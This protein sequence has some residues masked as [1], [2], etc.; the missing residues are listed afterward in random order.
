MVFVFLVSCIDPYNPPQV[1]QA[2]SYLVVDGYVDLDAGSAS[3]ILSRTKNLSESDEIQP[4]INA[5]VSVQ[6]EGGPTY[7]LLEGS[8]GMYSADGLI[9]TESDRCKLIISSE[10][11]NYE[12]EIVPIKKTPAIDSVTYVIDNSGVRIE[13]TTHDPTNS[14]WYYQWTFEETAKYRSKFQ[15]VNYYNGPGNFPFYNADNQIHVCWQT[16]SSTTILTATST[17]LKEDVI[18]K[19]PLTFIPSD[20]WK[21]EERYSILVKQFALDE[22]MYN[23]WVELRKNT[24]SL[25]TL[26]DPQ[27]SQ[28]TGNIRCTSDPLEPVLG[29]FSVRAIQE[30]RIYVDASELPP[31]AIIDG[32]E[33]C[34]YSDIDTLF[35]SELTAGPPPGYLLINGVTAPMGTQIIGYTAHE[36]RCIDCQIVRKGIPKRP[37]WWEE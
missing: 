1:Q 32:Y 29:Y 7:T 34:G 37:E 15:A 19:F 18:Y 27:P 33:Q 35:L 31:Y 10:G 5:Q 26:F 17:N 6:V 21:L 22:K 28:V 36:A 30:M 11:K 25:G 9:L 16:L 20:S 12:S 13:V 3:I 24:E 23:Y 8:A 4:Q 14:T 2:N